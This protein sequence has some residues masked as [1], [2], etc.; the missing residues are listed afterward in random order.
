MTSHFA[1][2]LALQGAVELSVFF[3]VNK[4]LLGKKRRKK[5]TPAVGRIL[6]ENPGIA[7]RI[8]D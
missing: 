7:T 4:I 6:L 1:H 5:K 2:R 8:K 3:S